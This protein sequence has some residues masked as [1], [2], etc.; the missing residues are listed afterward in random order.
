MADIIRFFR[1]LNSGILKCHFKV[2]LISTLN[3]SYYIFSFMLFLKYILN[4]F[5]SPGNS[6]SNT[7]FIP[8]DAWIWIDI[9][10]VR[11]PDFYYTALNT[12]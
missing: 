1:D 11:I 3:T 7:K 4:Y 9:C 5:M 12:C 8:V 2:F 10:D 6:K